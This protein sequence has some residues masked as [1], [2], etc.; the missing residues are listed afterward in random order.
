MIEKVN[1]RQM[2]TVAAIG[3]VVCCVFGVFGKPG[4]TIS[5]LQTNTNRNLGHLKA[6]QSSV[7]TEINR[8]Q[9]E[10]ANALG[11]IGRTQAEISGSRETISDLDEGIKQFQTILAEC[12]RLATESKRII[13]RIDE[14]N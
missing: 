11:A 6:E 14:S 9:I 8:S 10:T 4:T 2:L 12:E 7:G 13:E 3:L 5:D 1:L